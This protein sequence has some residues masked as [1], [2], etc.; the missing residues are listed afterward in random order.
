[1]AEHGAFALDLDEV[2]KDLMSPGSELL[3]KVGEAFPGCVAADGSLDREALARQAFASPERCARLNAIVHPAVVREVGPAITDLR[4]LPQRPHVVVM[5]VP[6]LAEAPVLAELADLV[7]AVSAPEDVRITRA[8]RRG[9]TEADARARL[10]CQS[11]DAEREAL[12]DVVLRNTGTLE[13]LRAAVERM[14]K[15]RV[16]PHA[17]N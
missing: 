6:L 10:A 17:S 4:L 13:E 5:Q 12:A 15:E 3:G 9:M 1:M 2:A 7:V 11:S 14:W 8:V 16:G